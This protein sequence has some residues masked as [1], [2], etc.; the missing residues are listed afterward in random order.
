M[1]RHNLVNGVIDLIRGTIEC[2]WLREVL[3]TPPIPGQPP[4]DPYRLM[5]NLMGLTILNSFANPQG[6]G[7]AMSREIDKIFLRFYGKT[8]NELAMMEMQSVKKEPA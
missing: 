5:D 7:M 2:D 3:N 4:P 1:P 8:F 6:D